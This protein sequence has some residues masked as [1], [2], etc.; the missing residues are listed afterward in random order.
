[1]DDEFVYQ[2]AGQLRDRDD[3]FFAQDVADLLE[4]SDVGSV[5]ESLHRLVARGLLMHLDRVSTPGASE[6]A[7]EYEGFRFPPEER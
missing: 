5:L 1:V 7:M 6:D 4:E 3:R 2:T